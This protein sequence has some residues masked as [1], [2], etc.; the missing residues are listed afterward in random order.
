M[1][2]YTKTGDAGETGLFCGTRITKSHPRINAYG[3][4]DELNAHIGLARAAANEKAKTTK[5]NSILLQSLEPVQHEL[6]IIG[7]HLAN[8]CSPAETPKTLP[9]LPEGAIERMESDIDEASESL[10]ELDHF[11]LPGG[12]VVA[13]QLHVARTVCRRAERAA[14]ELSQQEEVA[15]ILIQY[16]NR[17]SDLLFVLARKTNAASGKSETAWKG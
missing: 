17:L 9:P 11:I 1:K 4:V 7:S 16:L 12:S 5:D 14:V 15:P 8:Q 3:Q 6:F 2:I 10:P 13:S